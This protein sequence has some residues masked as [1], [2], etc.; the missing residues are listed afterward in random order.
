MRELRCRMGFAN[1]PGHRMDSLEQCLYPCERRR[2]KD[3]KEFYETSKG[4]SREPFLADIVQNVGW[5]ASGASFTVL[6]RNMILVDLN[7]PAPA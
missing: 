1:T 5:S 6:T 2:L 3:W 4:D 7:F